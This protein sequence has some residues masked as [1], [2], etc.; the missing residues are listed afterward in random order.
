M[1]APRVSYARDV[2]EL[3]DERRIRRLVAALGDVAAEDGTCYLAG[4]VTA[5]LLG[6]RATTLD[7]DVK[8]EPEQDEVLRAIPALKEELSVNVELA[9]PADFLP[10][11]QG[12]RE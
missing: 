11:P 5:V 1:S 7:V 6:W 3:A 8:L 2:R 9:S 4:G 12:W 10:L